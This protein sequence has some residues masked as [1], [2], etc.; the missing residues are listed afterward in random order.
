[1]RNLIQTLILLLMTSS[2]LYT[3]YSKKNCSYC[4]RAIHLIEDQGFQVQ[5]K[6]IDE[7]NEYFQEMRNLAPSMRTMPVIFKNN[8]LIGGYSDLVNHFS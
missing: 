1:M 3:V 4:D 5:I 7:N 2:E 6:K 8:T